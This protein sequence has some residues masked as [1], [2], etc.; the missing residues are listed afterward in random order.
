MTSFNSC[1]YAHFNNISLKFE[2]INLCIK[3]E[4]SN[5]FFYSYVININIIYLT[6]I[7][8]LE[9]NFN[10]FKYCFK[11]YSFFNFNFYCLII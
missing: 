3:I 5:L 10:K 7:S 1:I 6:S 9:L 11:T 8:N 2:E 4:E